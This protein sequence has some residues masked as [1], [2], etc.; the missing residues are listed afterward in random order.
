MNSLIY[1]TA[2][3]LFFPTNIKY[4]RCKLSRDQ[5]ASKLMYSLHTLPASKMCQGKGHVWETDYLYWKRSVHKG[6]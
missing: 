6:I 1:F 5:G 4:F 2:K 3:N